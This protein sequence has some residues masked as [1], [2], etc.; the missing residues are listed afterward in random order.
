MSSGQQLC[1]HLAV[2]ESNFLRSIDGF[3]WILFRVIFDGYE[4]LCRKRNKIS[5]TVDNNN[6]RNSGSPFHDQYFDA[7]D[8]A[9][10]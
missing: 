9:Y 5:C 10:V 2:S 3:F 4:I 6:N 8:C 7:A 1:F